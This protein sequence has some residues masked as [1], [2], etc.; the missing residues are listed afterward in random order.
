MSAPQ[1]ISDDLRGVLEDIAAAPKQRLFAGSFFRQM[2]LAFRG[3]DATVGVA[4]A[5]LSAA[6]RH[7]VAMHRRELALTLQQAFYAQFFAPGG[8]AGLFFPA[9]EPMAKD[10]WEDQARFARDTAPTAAFQSGT[11]T[12]LHRLLS[13]ESVRTATEFQSL[14]AA[15]RL[16][17]ESPLT[18]LYSGIAY[19]SFGLGAS[20][21]AVF[22]SL[23]KRAPARIQV[24]S[25]RCLQ[26]TLTDRGNHIGAHFLCL[27]TLARVD[28]E[29][30][31]EEVIMELA[32]LAMREHAHEHGLPIPDWAR[33]A[34]RNQESGM[35]TAYREIIDSMRAAKSAALGLCE[36]IDSDPME[37]FH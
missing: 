16:L 2:G 9:K 22:T 17:C 14:L 10:E 24:A 28:S 11:T 5:G 12:W 6:E 33:S 3:E 23:L 34:A 8:P 4:R 7:L 27:Q 19:D 21:T 29:G 36:F 1:L 26:S 32:T 37:L 18:Q 13:G 35:Q 31:E 30:W 25:M 20:A 15:S